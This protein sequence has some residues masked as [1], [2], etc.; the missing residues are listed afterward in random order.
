M[1]HARQSV[2]VDSTD[3]FEGD[4]GH[5]SD[6]VT[7][8]PV[9]DASAAVNAM[10]ARGRYVSG[11]FRTESAPAKSAPDYDYTGYT[12]AADRYAPVLD[13]PPRPRRVSSA[14]FH[15]LQEWE[16]YVLHIGKEDFEARLIDMTARATHE[17]EEATIPL[18]ELSDHDA[19]KLCVGAIFR[20]VIGYERTTGGS[21]RRVSQIVFRDLPAVT[22]S[23][24]ADGAAWARDMFRSLNS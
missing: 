3:A 17:G 13:L 22:K 4:S 8:A 24:L 10:L 6:I 20:W 23:D 12:Q 2:A 16:G 11:S 15:A 19:K 5:K 7:Q 1:L 14:T 18:Q 21:R 9:W